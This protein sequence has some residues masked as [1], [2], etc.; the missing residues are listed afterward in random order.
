MAIL[1]ST[2]TDKPQA[3][4]KASIKQL[5]ILND[6]FMTMKRICENSH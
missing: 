3:T 4:N 2:A 1:T 6:N 5:Y